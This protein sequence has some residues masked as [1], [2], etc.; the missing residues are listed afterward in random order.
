MSQNRACSGSS[1]ILFRF[2]IES[3]GK[4]TVLGDFRLCR[5]VCG[6]MSIEPVDYHLPRER[7]M[8]FIVFYIFK[9]HQGD[10]IRL[11]HYAGILVIEF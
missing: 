2:N 3:Y 1:S 8:E 9:C 7:S 11:K 4:N 5:R 6:E 10:K